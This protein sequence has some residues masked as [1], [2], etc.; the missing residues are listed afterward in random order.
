MTPVS[1]QQVY[2]EKTV[3]K[4][5]MGHKRFSFWTLAIPVDFTLPGMLEDVSTDCS[6]R[7]QLLRI[8]GY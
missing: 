2:F 6:K 4:Y 3:N 7:Q 1:R 5:L 8:W